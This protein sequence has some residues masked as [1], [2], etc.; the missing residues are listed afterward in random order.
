MDTSLQRDSENPLSPV[1]VES[2]VISLPG[3]QQLFRQG[4]MLADQLLPLDEQD[5]LT[6]SAI[7]FDESE[8]VT[9]LQ[10]WA[11]SGIATSLQQPNQHHTISQSDAQAWAQV[12][13]SRGIS[14]LRVGNLDGA[15]ENFAQA[16]AKYP[17]FLE[18]WVGAGIAQ[19]WLGDFLDAAHSFRQATQQHP[20]DSIYYC[21]LGTSLYRAGQM[22]DAIAA[23]QEA[24][25]INPEDKT[26]YYCLGVAATHTQDY[27]QAISAFQQAI[28]LS[29]HHAESYYGLGYVHFLLQDYPAAIAAVGAAKQH[30][31]KYRPIYERFLKHCLQ[32]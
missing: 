10:T 9:V 8:D 17:D 11:D 14:K 20:Q 22:V 26:A 29:R 32:K 23:Y 28:A 16:L 13:F 4:L 1:T 5:S 31:A 25:R 6:A 18:A 12:W 15:K 7:D 27:E 30:S 19:Y 2:G 3:H 21:N 24:V